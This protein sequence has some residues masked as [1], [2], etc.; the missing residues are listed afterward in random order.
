M[1]FLLSLSMGILAS[2]AQA[3][4]CPSLLDT[5]ELSPE[6]RAFMEDPLV[7]ARIASYSEDPAFLNFYREIE[8][9]LT[10]EKKVGTASKGRVDLRIS[11]GKPFLGGILSRDKYKITSQLLIEKLGEIRMALKLDSART[12]ASAAILDLET[13]QIALVQKLFN[14]FSDPEKGLRSIKIDWD[15]GRDAPKGFGEHLGSLGFTGKR[16]RS[17]CSIPG[18]VALAIFSSGVGGLAGGGLAM[19]ADVEIGYGDNEKGV[20]PI[21]VGVGALSAGA[22]VT[23]Y[24]CRRKSAKAGVYELEFRRMP[25][26]R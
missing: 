22:I 13:M 20:F 25:K 19:W 11:G 12:S 8:A 14:A 6:V 21:G 24:T 23:S 4:V 26:N 16:G 17:V 18:G 1:W 7:E 5:I 3:E 2:Y 15:L 9:W 10:L